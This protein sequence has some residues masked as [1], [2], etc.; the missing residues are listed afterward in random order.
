MLLNK[1]QENL[2][3][4]IEKDELSND[5]VVQLIAYLGKYLNLQTIPNYCKATG[6]SYNGA[7]NF[8]KIVVLFNVKF[9]VDN[10]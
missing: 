5:E 9:V 1:I 2:G 7:K 6:I 4:K 10:D 3:K 8:R